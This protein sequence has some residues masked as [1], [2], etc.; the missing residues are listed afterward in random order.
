MGISLNKKNN[1]W[2]D[3]GVFS[4]HLGFESAESID[5]YTLTRSLSAESSPYF[6]SG[7]K[8]SYE[9][10]DQLSI[11]AILSNGWQRIRR[12]NGNSMMSVG[13]QVVYTPKENITLNWSTFFTTEDPDDSR[14]IRS[15]HNFYG[16]AKIN[17]KLAVIGGLDIGRQ[18]ETPGSNVKET[19]YVASGIVR[20]D[21]HENWGG[22]LRFEYI[23]DVSGIIGPF[24]GPSGFSV[25]GLSVNIDYLPSE[26]VAARTELRIFSAEDP[27]FNNGSEFVYTNIAFTSS[28]AVRIFN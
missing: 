26:R 18:Q 5:N 10:S 4:S 25:T 22:A 27:I 15:F 9:H 8:I 16:Q 24:N 14:R 6:L 1:L 13:S 17:S 3:A 23:E 12:V 7:A 11:T 2:L 21:F 19:W 28:L 20:L